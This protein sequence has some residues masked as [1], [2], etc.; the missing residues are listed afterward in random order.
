[1]SLGILIGVKI[2]EYKYL[3]KNYTDK[4][5]KHHV[6]GKVQGQVQVRN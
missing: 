1:M 4:T 3:K 5:R 2:E 6:Q